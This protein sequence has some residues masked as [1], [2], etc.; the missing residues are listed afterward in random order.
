MHH[1]KPLCVVQSQILQS[2]ERLVRMRLPLSCT[3]SMDK[4]EMGGAQVAS[5]SSN[6]SDKKMG[7][8]ASDSNF[9]LE[10]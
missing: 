10:E 6:V 3:R 7:R 2:A 8:A 5:T 1:E 4:T 9:R